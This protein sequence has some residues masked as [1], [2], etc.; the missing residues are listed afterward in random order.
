MIQPVVPFF[1]FLFLSISTL[2]QSQEAD[3]EEEILQPL[4]LHTVYYEKD[5]CSSPVGLSTFVHDETLWIIGGHDNVTQQCSLELTCIIDGDGPF[6]QNEL[7]GNVEQ[8][9]IRNQVAK[10]GRVF[11]CDQSNENVGQDDCRFLTDCYGS[12][13]FPNCHFRMRSSGAIAQDPSLVRND[14]AEGIAGLQH[15]AYLNL[16][17]DA[18][19]KE[20]LGID[21]LVAGGARVLAHTSESMTCREASS[22]LADPNGATCESFGGV[23]DE[24]TT[25]NL[26]PSMGK[27]MLCDDL[28]DESTC[29]LVEPTCVQS[30][31]FPSCYQR[32]VASSELLSNPE[33]YFTTT[34]EPMNSTTATDTPENE[35]EPDEEEEEE[36]LANGASAA[37]LK[38]GGDF[39]GSVLFVLFGGYCFGW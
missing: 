28:E 18:E 14:N 36:P 32:L 33:V 4:L 17:E 6:C 10:D 11:Q 25:Y 24:T 27:A 16:Y 9:E 2:V 19:C 35:V 7:T 30:T 37:W 15:T 8:Y 26:R 29:A 31:I 12:S 3:D 39:A 20:M 13:V 23:T 5:D 21:G 34:K 1:L 38:M 22:C